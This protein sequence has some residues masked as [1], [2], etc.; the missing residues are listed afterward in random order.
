MDR[1]EI[2]QIAIDGAKILRDEA[3]KQPDVE[4]HFEYSPETFSTAELDFS[5]EVCEA[6]MEVLRP[7]PDRPLIFNL[8]ATVTDLPAGADFGSLV[9]A[10]LEH[11]DP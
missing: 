11:A 4:W 2:K 5:L 9:H 3:A 6:V 10:V 1:S 7:T 8:P